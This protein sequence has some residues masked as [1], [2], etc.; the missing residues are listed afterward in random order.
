M[1]I[2]VG[3]SAIT[4]EF[5]AAQMP[6]GA[7]G[8]QFQRVVASTTAPAA[9]AQETANASLAGFG[10]NLLDRLQAFAGRAQEFSKGALNE[11]PVQTPSEDRMRSAITALEKMF[12][13]SIEVQMV[14]R[15]T[16][17][18]SGSANTLLRGQ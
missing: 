9:P 10:E 8:E 2:S 11:K 1:Q 4:P 16:T 12:D 7:A 17:Q 15:G 3:Q 5:Q 13:H 18:V 14:V 6:G